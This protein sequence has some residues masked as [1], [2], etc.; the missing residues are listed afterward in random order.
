MKTRITELFGIEHPIIGGAMG[1]ISTATLVAAQSNA[2]ILGIMVSV[3]HQTKDA[4]RQ[5]IR[6]CKSL[7]DKPFAVNINLFPS[8]SGLKAEDYIEVVLEEEVPIIETSGRSPEPYISLIR[9]GKAKYMHKCARIRDAVKVQSLGADAVEIVG[10]ECGGHP[11]MED[12]TTIVIAPLTADAVSIPL[13]VGGGIADGRGLIAALAL[14]ADGVIMGTRFLAT[15][16]C[17]IHPNVKE[18]MTKATETDTTIV[19]RSVRSNSRV[20]KNEAAL[21]CLEMEARG[22]SLEE[23][24]TVIAGSHNRKVAQEGQM[25]AGTFACGEIVGLIK[26]VPTVKEVVDRIMRQAKEVQRRLSL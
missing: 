5:E 18:W 15:Q 22:A 6:K 20:I 4:L 24:M 7:T 12:I 1:S 14:G 2:G 3:M 26:D 19:Q 9:Q 8:S 25:N 21:K 23:L 16:E 10:F 17:P 13:I 11:G